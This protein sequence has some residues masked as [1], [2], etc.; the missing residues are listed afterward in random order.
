MGDNI[1]IKRGN[2]IL[3]SPDKSIIFERCLIINKTEAIEILA[4]RSLA[5][6]C[7]SK[8]LVLVRCLYSKKPKKTNYIN[9][10]KSSFQYRSFN[11]LKL[12]QNI[13]Y[14]LI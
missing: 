8:M 2:T 11:L 13:L 5:N 1:E 3:P 6:D 12:F 9:K 7:I 14:I 10:E 4:E